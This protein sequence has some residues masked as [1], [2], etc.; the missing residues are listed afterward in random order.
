MRYVVNPLSPP[1]AT[2]TQRRAAGPAGTTTD[3]DR[4][5]SRAAARHMATALPTIATGRQAA[6]LS[7][8]TATSVVSLMVEAA[9]KFYLVRYLMHQ[10]GDTAYGVWVAIGGVL[11]YGGILQFALNSAVNWQVP[12]K[13]N[14]ND[15][16][17]L[18]EVVSTAFAYYLSLGA[19]ILV[20]VVALVR[21]VPGWLNVPAPFTTAAEIVFVITG[22]SMALRIPV[23]VF[24]GVVSGM[25]AYVAVNACRVGLEVA[26]LA[27]ILFLVGHGFGVVTVCVVYASVDLGNAIFGAVLCF[28]RIPGLRA[29]PRHFH[30]PL[31]KRL[32]GYGFNTLLYT[33]WTP[34]LMNGTYAL[35]AILMAPEYVSRYVVA[36]T[37]LNLVS[38]VSWSVLMAVKPAVSSLQAHGEMALVRRLFLRS[39]KYSLM[40]LL[41]G[42]ALL[43]IMGR[44]LIALWIKDPT[45]A[46]MAPI[47]ALL[48]LGSVFFLAQQSA[49]ITLIGLGKH[50]VFGLIT[51][52][53][54]AASLVLDIVF[55]AGLGWGLWGIALGTTIPLLVIG[56]FFLPL[57]TSG[58]LGVGVGQ[59][60][61]DA[62][63][64]P[65]LAA[66]PVAALALLFRAV[67]YPSTWMLF[68][69]EVG[70]IGI[71]SLAFNWRVS[72]DAGERQFFGDLALLK[73]LLRRRATGDFA[74]PVPTLQEY[75]KRDYRASHQDR[76]HAASYDP[77]FLEDRHRAIMWALEQEALDDVLKRCFDGRPIQVLDF[78][79]GT[80]RI[81]AFL[82]SRGAS[83]VGVDIS[84]AMLE[85]ARQKVCRFELIEADLTR[86]DVLGERTFDLVTAFRFFPNAEPALRREALHVMLGHIAPGG[87]LV[88][89]NHLNHSSLQRRVMRLLRRPD[90]VFSMTQEEVDNLLAEAGLRVLR[91]YTIG[92]FPGTIR[93]VFLPP[94]LLAALEHGASRLGWFKGLSQDLVFVCQKIGP[95]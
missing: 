43:S 39:Q 38:Q 42:V 44:P 70:V 25:Q 59:M 76:T 52:L 82:E 20:G 3:D 90:S 73:P 51:T 15:R 6:T 72:L 45:K 12:Q 27:A 80:A 34:V 26:R 57:H 84:A 67:A 78:A 2:F 54:L 4:E 89:N 86:H 49:G 21:W 55:V 14:A 85:Y 62:W 50:R 41:P 10:L 60:V 71:V 22:L 65:L 83:G 74:K 88:F 17:G 69:G 9:V 53:G 58:E 79:C 61:R 13:L 95:H 24:D 35:I 93:H 66:V 77:A 5:A 28:V 16:A 46:E 56:A 75:L 31:F 1:A 29:S 40:L 81:A 30:W 36:A 33:M 94:R 63:Q 18:N 68:I 47:L 32:L 48:L 23:S 92:L 37:V 7:Y 87:C 91:T 8:N 64:R 19:A 11:A